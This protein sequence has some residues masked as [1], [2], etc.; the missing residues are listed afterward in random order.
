MEVCALASGSS[1]NCF[2]ASSGKTNILIDVGISCKNIEEKMNLLGKKIS[3]INGAFITHEHI[4]HIRGASAL[5][6][7]YNIPIFSTKK[8]FKESDIF[9]NNN[10][11]VEVK[12]DENIILNDMEVLCFQKKHKSVDPVGFSI[13]DKRTSKKASIITDLGC[14]NSRVSEQISDSNVL[15]IEA[16]H[17]EQM[18]LDGPYPNFL[19]QWVKS[20][21]GHLSNLQSAL[22]T[23]E[24]ANKKLREIILCHISDSNNN[25]GVAI[26]T[27]KKMISHR[28]D[29]SANISVS[30]KNSI[31]KN[32]HL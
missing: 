31:S 10:L 2:L 20:D 25:T 19:K 28:S 1:G 15:F 13:I 32:I 14:I 26:N 16:N 12:H 8:L 5:S 24:Y 11:N 3:D 23:M 21:V 9:S 4:D 7:R 27:Y 6:S 29:L 30:L 18:L 22:G 17:D